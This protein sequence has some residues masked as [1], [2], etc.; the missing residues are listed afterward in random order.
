M[1][2]MVRETPQTELTPFHPRSPYGCAKVFGHNITVNYR[3][4][5]GL[6]ACSGILFN[7]EGPWRG[8]EFVTR[9]I[10]NAVARIKLGLQENVALG[11]LD[12]QRDWGYAGDYVK[13]MWLMMQQER[14]DDYVVATGATHSVREFL[15]LAFA[16][17]GIGDWSKLVVRDPAM[18]RPAEVDVLIGDASKARTTLGWQPEVDFPGL[19]QMMVRHDLAVESAKLS[20]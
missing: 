10:S 1:F 14:P 5:Y 8:L 4:S 3:E 13:A 9:K 7:H 11:N 2:G 19:V 17:V 12:A 6:Y 18:I 15:D 16:E 20:K